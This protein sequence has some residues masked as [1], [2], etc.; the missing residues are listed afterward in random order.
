MRQRTAITDAQKAN[1]LADTLKENF[2]E[3]IYQNRDTDNHINNTV[4]TFISTNPTNYLDP[5]LPDEIITY[6]K[7][8]ALKKHLEDS[9][10]HSDSSLKTNP[11]CIN[12]NAKG[13]MASS[14]ECP[15][16]PKP[17]KGKGQPQKDNK[18]RNETT[19]ASAAIITPRLEFCSSCSRQ[20]TPTE[21]STRK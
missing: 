11:T 17:R 2:T 9:L 10:F 6:I 8:L 13:H 5:V 18:K 12:C 1:P 3:N 20:K 16:F 19:Q 7:N 14:T 15:L 21:G 4:N